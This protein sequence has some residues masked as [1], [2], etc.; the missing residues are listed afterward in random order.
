MAAKLEIRLL[1]AATP[2][3]DYE[4]IR[5]GTTAYASCATAAGGGF[6]GRKALT[7]VVDLGETV[8]NWE[9]EELFDE[10]QADI[11]DA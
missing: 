2:Q 1:P 11:D 7:R 5:P 3:E 4:D 8:E 10:L 6:G 9:I